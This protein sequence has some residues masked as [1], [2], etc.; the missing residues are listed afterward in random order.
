MLLAEE[1]EYMFRGDP[2]FAIHYES[3]TIANRILVVMR[4]IQSTQDPATQT[5]YMQLAT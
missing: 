5:S 1:E 2:D 3:E 4:E